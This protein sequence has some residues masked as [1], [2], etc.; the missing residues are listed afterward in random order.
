MSDVHGLD[1]PHH[2][3]KSLS[4]DAIHQR[5]RMA[6]RNGQALNARCFRTARLSSIEQVRPGPDSDQRSYRV[7][8]RV[9]VVEI[10]AL[11]GAEN[12]GL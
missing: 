1:S 7:L 10:T 2:N 12:H 8:I 5:V 9:L 3:A 4:I 6:M 11:Y